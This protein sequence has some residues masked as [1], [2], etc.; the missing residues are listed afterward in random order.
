MKTPLPSN[1]SFGT[2]FV[3]VFAAVGAWSAWRSSASYPWWLAAALATLLVT[4]AAPALLTP[5]NRAWMA[6][7]DL[8]GRI[9]SPV[10]L[11]ILFFG[12]IAPFGIVR[13]LTGWDPMRRKFDPSAATYWIERSPPGPSGD[14]LPN[15]F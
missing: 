2:L 5:F 13:R 4:L 1:R 6:L 15:Q 9:V 12:V 14:S 3:V 8:M 7:G 11:G 10:V